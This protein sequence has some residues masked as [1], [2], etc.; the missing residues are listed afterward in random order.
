ML[1]VGAGLFWTMAQLTWHASRWRWFLL[2]D[3][4]MRRVAECARQVNIR[5]AR[6]DTKRPL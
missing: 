2:D 3:G 4:T 6:L 5:Q 1:L